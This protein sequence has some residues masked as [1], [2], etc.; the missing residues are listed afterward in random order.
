VVIRNNRIALVRKF[1]TIT[2]CVPL[3][4]PPLSFSYTEGWESGHA[5]GTDHEAWHYQL[6]Q[7]TKAAIAKEATDKESMISLSVVV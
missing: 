6:V 5:E 4:D 7:P 3:G 1:F 2:R